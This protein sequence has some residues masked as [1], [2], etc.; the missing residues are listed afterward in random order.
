MTPTII[1]I[2]AIQ[3]AHYLTVQYTEDVQNPDTP[4]NELGVLIPVPCKDTVFVNHPSVM[5]G[6]AKRP[7]HKG[8]LYYR[9]I[10]YAVKNFGFRDKIVEVPTYLSSCFNTRTFEATGIRIPHA[11]CHPIWENGFTEY[12]DRYEDLKLWIMQNP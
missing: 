9:G 11:L 10:Y 4:E 2:L 5:G 8:L 1:R 7:N 12:A 3:Q 6:Y